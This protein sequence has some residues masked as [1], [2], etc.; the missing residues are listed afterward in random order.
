M[1][2][3]IAKIDAQARERLLLLQKAA[4]KLGIERR[5]VHGHIT[6]GVYT[7]DDEAAFTASCKAI[8]ERFSAFEVAY[9]RLEILREPSTIVACLP[10]DGTLA[11]LQRQ[12]VEV[13]AE[14]LHVWSQ[15]G[16]WL[17]HTTLVQNSSA[18][19]DAALEAMQSAFVP[20]HA[21]I[22]QIEFSAV[23]P[24]GY[25]IVDSVQLK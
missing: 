18:N 20:F 1:L 23:R 15:P 3:V 24:D 12:I 17:P 19:L 16:I 9:E 21:E 11:E 13:W 10:K 25:E 22:R 7:G 4:E 14:K 6:L 8:S 2:C 5:H